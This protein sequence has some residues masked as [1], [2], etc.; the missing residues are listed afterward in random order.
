MPGKILIEKARKAF[1]GD[2]AVFGGPEVDAGLAGRLRAAQIEVVNGYTPWMMLACIV[3]AGVLVGA[4]LNTP[5]FAWSLVWASFVCPA[6]AFVYLRWWRGRGLP[7]R[8]SVSVRATHRAI[9]NA[10]MYGL[11][12]G[13]APIFFFS[14]QSQSADLVIVCLCAGMM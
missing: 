8:A 2:L 1:D 12:W 14:G 7:Q 9:V 10:A 4:M 13:L 3:N 5:K 11:I 6:A